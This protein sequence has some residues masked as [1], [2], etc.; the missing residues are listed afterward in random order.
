MRYTP[1]GTPVTNFSLAVNNRRRDENGDWVEDTEWF[2]ITAWER[3]A[4]SVNQYL[5]KG[6]VVFVDGRLS[7]RHYTNSSGEARTSLEVR[8]SNIRFLDSP[9]GDS[10]TGGVQTGTE[11]INPVLVGEAAL[12]KE[13]QEETTE[14]TTVGILLPDGLTFLTRYLR[15]DNILGRVG[16]EEYDRVLADCRHDGK[17]IFQVGFHSPIGMFS[18]GEAYELGA[19]ARIKRV[20]GNRVEIF[21]AE[22]FLNGIDPAE[23]IDYTSEELEEFEA[24]WQQEE[25]N[26]AARAAWQ[27]EEAEFYAAAARAA[28]QEEEAEFYAAAAAEATAAWQE[29]QVEA[30]WQEEHEFMKNMSPEGLG[31]NEID[32]TSQD[33]E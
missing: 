26:A 18:V 11:F 6:H 9:N 14:A 25:G 3:Q 12:Q 10:T 23:G 31:P 22:I 15:I 13:S 21:R 28:W 30:A 24:A 27:E 2:R 16:N 4:E 33:Y 1:N 29:E 32:T 20:Q 17:F 8:A 7:T 19:T 5:A